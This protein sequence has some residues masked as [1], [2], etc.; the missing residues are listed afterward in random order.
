MKLTLAHGRAQLPFSIANLT[1]SGGGT[2]TVSRTLYLSIQGQNYLGLNL[3]SAIVAVTVGVGQ[4]LSITPPTLLPAEEWVNFVISASTTAD[5]AT[6]AQIGK[7]PVLTLGGQINTEPLELS[8]DESFALSK[9]VATVSELPQTGVNGMMRG[10]S[11]ENTI[12]EYDLY[13]ATWLKSDR[14]FNTFIGDPTR[15]GGCA[16]DIRFIESFTPPTYPDDGSQGTTISFWMVNDSQFPEPPGKRLGMVVKLNNEVK[17]DYFDKKLWLVFRGH[18]NTATNEIRTIDGAGNAFKFVDQGILFS[19]H[20]SSLVLNDALYPG[21]AYALDIYPRFN[22]NLVAG[23]QIK[24][25]PFF[26]EEAGEYSDAGEIIG[27]VIYPGGDRCLVVPGTQLSVRV[28]TGSGLVDSF[29]FLSKGEKLVP[30]LVANTANQQIAINGNGYCRL[31]TSL[32]PLDQTEAIR[33]YV[34]TLD[35][36]GAPSDWSPST[37]IGE[38]SSVEVT[39]NYPVADDGLGIIRSDYPDAKIASKGKA[40]FNPTN[41]VIYL[42]RLSDNEI[43]AFSL[44]AVVP[45]P[46]Q[47]FNLGSWASGTRITSLPTPEQSDFGL[48]SALSC[49]L[50]K[51]NG[52]SDFAPVSYQAAFAFD[53]KNAVTSISHD[54]G[55]GCIPTLDVT[56]SDTISRSAYWAEAVATIEALRGV[57]PEARKAGQHRSVLSPAGAFQFDAGS[58]A[59]DNGEEVVRPFG[60]EADAPGRWI[61][62]S[63]GNSK[64]PYVDL[65]EIRESAVPEINKYDQGFLY[66][67]FSSGLLQLRRLGVTFS[68][69]LL[70]LTHVFK[71][72]QAVQP[73][74]IEPSFGTITFSMQSSN[75]FNTV[76]NQDALL[77]V[78]DMIPGYAFELKIQQSPQGEKKLTFPDYCKFPNGVKPFISPESGK[79]DIL[80]CVCFEEN[81]LHCALAKD[82]S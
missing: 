39:C 32:A 29:R 80:S 57:S 22:L 55:E 5:P 82:F 35:G 11:N 64:K 2:T 51:T 27:D 79:I 28:L 50:S 45:D 44:N 68:L 60:I 30:N 67:S 59:D 38:A 8:T 47:T 73:F 7:I 81:I 53:Y 14:I 75:R 49:T 16:Q 6:L 40:T 33:A 3:N 70:E 19:S 12:Y 74:T 66:L 63:G 34:S 13:S 15:N 76:M 46:D 61:I 31:T 18:V 48:F 9:M 25:Y 17:T 54:E 1:V 36:V 21:E 62:G 26:Y 42:K 71:R 37:F 23:V 52:S 10:V 24:V 4:K 78:Y 56:L 77:N 20:T 72:G 58:F 69:P 41:V 43:R 65:T